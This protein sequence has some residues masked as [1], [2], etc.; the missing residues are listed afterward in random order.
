[1]R[2]L[3]QVATSTTARRTRAAGNS[4]E[5][6]AAHFATEQT[7]EAGWPPL[8]GSAGPAAGDH[9]PRL[10]ARQAAETVVTENEVEQVVVL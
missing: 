9:A 8:A 6:L 10:V 4:Q 7:G 5:I 1:M 2:G 3:L